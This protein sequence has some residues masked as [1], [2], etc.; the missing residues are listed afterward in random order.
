MEFALGIAAGFFLWPWWAMMALSL[1]FIVDIVCLECEAEGW[2]TTILIIGTAL[3]TWLAIDANIFVWV[4]NNLANI[5][6]FF[7]VYFFVG[8]LWSVAKWYFYLL[9]VRDKMKSSNI[10][11]RPW[12]SYASNNKARIF[13]WIGHWPF[14]MVGTLFGDFLKRVVLSI[15]N[16]LSTLYEKIG[17]SVFAD[18]KEKDEPSSRY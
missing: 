5:G 11:T 3:L 7:L 12:E 16:M 4:W 1:V 13:S 14:S 15:Y 6:K 10:T 8:A 18:F 17:N 2:G 9:T